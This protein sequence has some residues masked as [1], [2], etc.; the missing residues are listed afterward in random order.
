MDL[1]FFL[2]SGGTLAL[3]GLI[4][5]FTIARKKAANGLWP[6]S[7]VVANALVISMVG[8]TALSIV[9]LIKSFAGDA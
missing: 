5:A 4:L 9:L 8:L 2:E 7:I 6:T 3:A 1:I